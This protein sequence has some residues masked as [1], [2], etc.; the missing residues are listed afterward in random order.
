ME[1]HQKNVVFLKKYTLKT[2][3]P[4]TSA[5]DINCL[6]IRHNIQKTRMIHLLREKSIHFHMLST[7]AIFV[8]ILKKVKIA[9]LF[10]SG[11]QNRFKHMKIQPKMQN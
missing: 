6:I 1:N 3:F 4:V 10:T 8:Y 2:I 9:H 5:L 11:F 7:K